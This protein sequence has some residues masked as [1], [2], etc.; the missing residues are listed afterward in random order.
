M[1]SKFSKPCAQESYEAALQ[2]QQESSQWLKEGHEDVYDQTKM[3]GE[4]TVCAERSKALLLRRKERMR[5]HQV[6]LA[7]I[8]A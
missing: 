4:S 8:A 7:S 5:Q 6:R 1:Y 2:D 3:L